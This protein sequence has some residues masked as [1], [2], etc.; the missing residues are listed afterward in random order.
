MRFSQAVVLCG[1]CVVLGGCMSQDTATK[2][3]GQEFIR[4]LPNHPE[5]EVRAGVVRWFSAESLS[6]QPGAE[7]RESEFVTIA[8]I[9]GMEIKPEGSWVSL[10]AAF[11]M[12]VDV[13]DN[14]IRVRF[15]DLRRMY[16]S[17][18]YRAESNDLFFDSPT[19]VPY[20]R[21]AQERFITLVKS[22]TDYI[23]VPAGSVAAGYQ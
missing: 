22:L 11:T 23:G 8:G 2:E 15:T 17:A 20:Q 10:K 1:A 7:H 9:G 21:A 16:G 12:N 3:P 6:V 5:S 4:D 13:K 14:R 19:G 18:L